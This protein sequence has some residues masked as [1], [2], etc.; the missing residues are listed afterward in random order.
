MDEKHTNHHHFRNFKEG[1]LKQPYYDSYLL[2]TLTER[3]LELKGQNPPPIS[4]AANLAVTPAS[5][6][7]SPAIPPGTPAQP[8]VES[9][10]EPPPSPASLMDPPCG[11]RT[12]E[13]G[14]CKY[15]RRTCPYHNG[16]KFRV[17]PKKRESCFC[18]CEKRREGDPDILLEGYQ[19]EFLPE[20]FQQ[21]LK[22]DMPQLP[23]HSRTHAH[24]FDVIAR[25]YNRMLLNNQSKP[26]VATME[27]VLKSVCV[28][29]PS[30]KPDKR[31]M[32]A[33]FLEQYCK[34]LVFQLEIEKMEGRP[35]IS[36]QEW[37]K[38]PLVQMA[39]RRFRRLEAFRLLY[40][41]IIHDG[42]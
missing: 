11:A 23:S 13:G 19:M 30:P 25:R 40:L 41:D 26:T 3:L 20:L 8:A 2:G 18:L 31:M 6:V 17:V 22:E 4:P 28:R 32:A 42:K 7:E 34:E 39:K 16:P 27:T 24:I 1:L 38:I 29:I 36:F 35:G 12:Y 10:P 15:K 5:A 9:P 37:N 14:A 21:M 33:L